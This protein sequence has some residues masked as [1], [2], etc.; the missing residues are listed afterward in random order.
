M[1]AI[2]EFLGIFV[3]LFVD[4]SF[5]LLFGLLFVALLNI[6]FTKER[7]VKYM[8]KDNIWSVIKAALLGVPL[9][10]CSCGVV[11]TVVYMAKNGA[12]RGSVI[13]F[14]IATP[15][16][17]VDSII[18]TYGMMGPFMAVFRPISALLTGIIGGSIIHKFP[19]KDEVIIKQDVA[20]CCDSGEDSCCDSTESSCCTSAPSSTHKYSSNK[21]FKGFKYAFFDFLDDIVPQ[22]LLGLIIAALITYFV[23]EDYFA[24]SGYNSGILGMLIMMAIGIP[25]Y[26]CAT[27]S[28]P[29][30]VSLILKGFSPGVAFVFL[31][32][33]P[34]TNA[35]TLAI[36][37]KTLGKQTVALY[38]FLLA[39][40]SIAFAYLLDYLVATFS[41][42]IRL[43]LSECVHCSPMQSTNLEIISGIIFA[44]LIILSLYRVYLKKYFI[45]EK[46]MDD[47]KYL[48]ITGMNCSH[49]SANVQKT[50]EA[51]PGLSNI[52]VDHKTGIAEYMGAADISM[53]KTKI[54]DI[55]Y[56]AEEHKI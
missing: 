41:I 23:P 47:K 20:S 4:M 16:T 8:G 54:Q 24:D 5:Y 9:P 55:G 33:G 34:A 19:S 50:L 10:L 56:S 52:S 25:M 36:L 2:Y 12:S 26:I 21:Y 53:L 49:C 42:D 48:K 3:N 1:N 18:A 35:A 31:F 27:A 11:P 44:A 28:I 32:T 22:F 46:T 38:F 6:Y 40:L 15:Q 30:A 51:I 39:I 14:L 45:K 13:S 29:I 37:I 43:Q 17:G 7:I